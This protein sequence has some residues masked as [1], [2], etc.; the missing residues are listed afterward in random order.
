MEFKGEAI[1]DTHLNL[2]KYT[3]EQLSAVLPA[4]PNVPNLILAGDI[5]DPDEVSLYNILQIAKQR[6]QRVLYI[7]GNHEFYLRTPGSKKSPASVLAWFDKLDTQWDNFHFFYRR[8]EV[9]DGIRVVGATAWS[10]SAKDTEWSKM[11]SEEGRKDVE[12]LDKTLS[13][14]KEPTQVVT[15]YPST[16]KVLQ[17][18]YANKLSQYDYA[19]D[20]ERMYHYPVKTWIFG[21]VHQSHDF[22]IPY[23]SSIYGSGSIRILCNPYGY[24]TDGI[25]SRYPVPFT[26]SNGVKS[27]GGK[28]YQT[29]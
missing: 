21:H 3:P 11:I 20:L 10:T 29:L 2:W 18:N 28:T 25:T 9:Y 15:H 5:G 22:M 8:T 7:P 14:S 1:S 19:Q 16:L 27:L 17:P 26:I 13:S 12:F 23:S 24:P 4:V 6:Y